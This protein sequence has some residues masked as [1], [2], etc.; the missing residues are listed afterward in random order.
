MQN[1]TNLPTEYA[2]VNSS[3]QD[4]RNILKLTHVEAGQLA[5]VELERTLFLLESLMTEDWQQPTACTLWNVREMAA[6][7]AG[8]CAGYASWTEF[9]R[10]YIQNPYLSEA[11][12]KID[13]INRRQV[14]DRTGATPA[15]LIAELREVG[16]K[17]IRTRQRLPWLLRVIPVPFG[18]P[19]GTVPVGYLTDLIYVRDMWMHRL[20]ICRAT[21]R[22]MTLTADHDGRIVALVMRDLGEKLHSE[23]GEGKISVTLTG[24]AGGT[25]D[26]GHGSIPS[27]TIQMD[28]LDFNWLASG[29]MTADEAMSNVVAGGDIDQVRWFLA[30]SEVPY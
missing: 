22:E 1:I 25:F 9:K 12:V 5:T 18:P 17:A 13:G 3:V 20:D 24:P 19:L 10:N 11:A 8:A 2:E 6:H 23:L 16:P 30:Y 14:E 21:G 28:A 27:A 15:A 4:A 29:R 7:L 26:F